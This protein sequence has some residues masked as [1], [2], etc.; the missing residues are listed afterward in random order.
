[1]SIRLANPC[2]HA[3]KFESKNKGM[4][5]MN[6]VQEQQTVSKLGGRPG[7]TFVHNLS[8]GVNG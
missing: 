7:N 8:A 4:R 3:K 5:E 1:M 6:F 2:Y